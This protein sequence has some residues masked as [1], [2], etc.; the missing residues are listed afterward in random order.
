LNRTHPSDGHDLLWVGFDATLRDD[1]SD[2]HTFW[3]PT[4]IFLGLSFM[5]F[6]QS[7]SKVF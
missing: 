6:S 1:K 3:D 5:S 4:D 2:K 7:F